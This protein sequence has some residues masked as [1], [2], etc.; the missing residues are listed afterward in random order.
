[1]QNDIPKVHQHPAIFSQ[2]FLTTADVVLL[3][4]LSDLIRDR[5]CQ[6]LYHPV[7][8]ASADYEIIS[9]RR[10]FMNI[11]EQDVFPLLIFQCVDD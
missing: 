2:A 5:I 7:A 9:E 3:V 10:V 11:Q 4:F 6:G 8:G 1:M